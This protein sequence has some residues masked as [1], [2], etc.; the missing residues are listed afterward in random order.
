VA[1]VPPP[2]KPAPEPP[3]PIPPRREAV[4]PK[5]PEK[6][7][8]ARKPK[9]RTPTEPKP[10]PPPPKARAEAPKRPSRPEPPRPTP[11]P[12]RSYDDVM[13]ELRKEKGDPRPAPVQES[14]A[15]PAPGA[16]APGVL[17]GPGAPVDPGVAAWLRAARI[18]VEE[19][20]VLPPG[21]QR[22]AL[23]A[24]VEVQLDAAGHVVAQPRVVQRSGNPWYDESVVRAIQKA[25]P[26]PPPPEPGVWQFEFRPPGG[27]A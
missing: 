16:A 27:A 1:A 13:A 18:H 15:S 17:G 19:A 20:W 21:F 12:E 6:A 2:P 9:E 7:P 4:L 14:T 3:K 26:L 11:P 25:S 10:E 22:E 8:E 24:V 5:T 23:Q